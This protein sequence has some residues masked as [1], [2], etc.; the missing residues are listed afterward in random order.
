MRIPL[1]PMLLLAGIVP[2]LSMAPTPSIAADTT[3][4]AQF[5]D[6]TPLPSLDALMKALEAWMKRFPTYSAPE[7]LPNGD[8]LIRR[9][10]P[11][12]PPSPDPPPHPTLPRPGGTAT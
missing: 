10:P 5:R 2:V 8:I 11:P 1:L 12:D 6:E 7:I 3:P 9:R 4:P